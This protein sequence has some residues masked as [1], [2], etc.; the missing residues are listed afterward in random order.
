[1]TDKSCVGEDALACPGRLM[2]NERTVAAWYAV[3]SLAI[4]VFALVTA[5]FLPASLLTPIA[6]DLGIT[7]G[8][9]GQAVTATALV[10]AIAGPAVVIGAGK[11]D[12]RK[13]I[14]GLSFMLVVSNL[15]AA[16]SSNI[17]EL[18]AAR[19]VLGI[20]LGGVWSLAAALVLRLVPARLLSRAM[21][22]IFTGVS[23]ATVC[24]PALGSYL[25][26]LWGWRATFLA[27]AGIG[28]LALMF[29]LLSLPRLPP[30]MAPSF[31]AFGLLL[32]RPGIRIG[33]ISVMFIISGHFAG[34]TYIR[35]FL[36]QVPQLDIRMISLVLLAF[37]IGGFFGNFAG[38]YL[39][40]RSAR[41][42]VAFSGI[43]LSAMAFILLADGALAGIAFFATAGWGF[44]FGAFPVSIQTWN[45]QAAPEHAETAGALLL[46]TFQIA[47]A[48]GASIGGL[49]TD[50]FGAPGA[51]TYSALA[52][53]I[54][55]LAML[56]FGR[57]AK[58]NLAPVGEE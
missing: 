20:A 28:I 45:T 53:L 29:Q 38:G 54:G 51:I 56:L 52:I 1:M 57:G 18:I 31:S 7:D 32:R 4:G 11:I 27:A 12:R 14:W 41:L 46:T 24:A 23:A 21:M 43:M 10:A 5:E 26:H 58:Q 49:L 37:G 16:V 17:W 30:A 19:V 50:N 55:G 48:L 2:D 6:G 47:I 35:P 22:I 44:A 34:F 40:E 42:A 13:V 8:A 39:A 3:L 25:G 9:A 15:L 33:L 36:E